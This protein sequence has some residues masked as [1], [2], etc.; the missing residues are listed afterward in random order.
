MEFRSEPQMNLHPPHTPGTFTWYHRD[1]IQLFVVF[2]LILGFFSRSVSL[3]HQLIS[4]AV[5]LILIQNLYRY[6][7]VLGRKGK[8]NQVVSA[9]LRLFEQRLPHFHHDRSRLFYSILSV[10]VLGALWNHRRM[11]LFDNGEYSTPSDRY[12]TLLLAWYLLLFLVI[13]VYLA[14]VWVKQFKYKDRLHIPFFEGLVGSTFFYHGLPTKSRWIT[15]FA[16]FLLGGVPS[17]F[18]TRIL[19]ADPQG[20]MYA[21]VLTIGIVT[22]TIGGALYTMGWQMAFE[23]RVEKEDN[24]A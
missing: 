10:V 2:I 21:N 7:S 5:V 18:A 6:V 24:S 12:W 17:F 3:T 16:G 8:L 23:A 22:L 14:V 15:F 9:R 19:P 4:F 1:E 11:L 13:A 20:I